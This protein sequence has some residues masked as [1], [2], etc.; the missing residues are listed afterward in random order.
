MELS[1]IMPMP[2]EVVNA[3]TVISFKNR[4]DKHWTNRQLLYPSIAP[5][6]PV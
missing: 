4:L 5:N 6:R 1:A 3:Q 2:Y